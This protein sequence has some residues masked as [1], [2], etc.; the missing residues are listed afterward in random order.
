MQAKARDYFVFVAPH[1]ARFPSMKKAWEF[2]RSQSPSDPS[3]PETASATI[4]TSESDTQSSTT[5]VPITSVL[6][7]LLRTRSSCPHGWATGA[8][9]VK[10]NKCG[11]RYSS[12]ANRALQLHLRKRLRSACLLLFPFADTGGPEAMVPCFEAL[13]SIDAVLSSDLYGP[14]GVGYVPKKLPRA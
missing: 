8:A 13:A 14:T 3:Q 12:D 6:S 11:A 5:A 4:V 10:R 9:N 2:F 1:G 7:S